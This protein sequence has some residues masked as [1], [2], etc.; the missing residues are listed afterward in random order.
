M[1]YTAEYNEG[2]IAYS[3]N[4]QL[5][6]IGLKL[7]TTKTWNQL[8]KTLNYYFIVKSYIINSKIRDFDWLTFALAAS[9]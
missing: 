7:K 1:H 2:D 3:V 4:P 6:E 5:I 9:S 8:N